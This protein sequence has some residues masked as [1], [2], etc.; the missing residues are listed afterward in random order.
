MEPGNTLVAMLGPTTAKDHPRF[1][2]RALAE[3]LELNRVVSLQLPLGRG[4][5]T[6]LFFQ[7]R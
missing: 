7:K 2:D 4:G 1:A 6:L 3:S 5:R